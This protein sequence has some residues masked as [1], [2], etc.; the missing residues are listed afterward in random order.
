GAACRVRLGPTQIHRSPR[1]SQSRPGGP[2]VTT[3]PTPPAISRILVEFGT[4]VHDGDELIQT[5]CDLAVAVQAELCG[6]LVED[7]SLVDLSGLPFARTVLPG[8][9]LPQ[10]LSPELVRRSYERLAATC[11]QALSRRA[12]GA[13]FSWTFDTARGHG[14]A[15][16]LAKV[17]RTDLVV[18]QQHALGQ[19][20]RDLII[21]AR[22][23]AA[24]ARGVVVMG[25]RFKRT[26]GPVVAIDDGHDTGL[27]AI[28]LAGRLARRHSAPVELFVIAGDE[29]SARRT[30]VRDLAVLENHT[31]VI[32]RFIA[33][34][35]ETIEDAL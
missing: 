24:V 7:E 6:L 17:S 11:R 30:E 31:V 15:E 4:N 14:A 20:T 16:I 21:T 32:R 29:E 27:Q 19:S 9:S 34:R 33:R 5:A 3:A 28:A 35:S 26:S 2:I 23:A 13:E 12:L 25:R 10:A 1:R 8:R 22:S 18:I